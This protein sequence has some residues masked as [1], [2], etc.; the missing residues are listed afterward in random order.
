MGCYKTLALSGG[1]PL[2]T[3]SEQARVNV[4]ATEIVNEYSLGYAPDLCYAMFQTITPLYTEFYV[5]KYNYGDNTVTK[6][7]TMVTPGLGLNM[8]AYAASHQVFVSSRNTRV[9]IYDPQTETLDSFDSGIVGLS[10]FMY[11]PEKGRVYGRMGVD[12]TGLSYIGY[13]DLDLHIVVQLGTIPASGASKPTPKNLVYV[14]SNDCL[15]GCWQTGLG[16]AMCKFNLTTLAGTAVVAAMEGGEIC[17]DTDRQLLIASSSSVKE[18]DPTTD[19]VV[20]TTP[21]TAGGNVSFTPFYVSSLKKVFG[22]GDDDFDTGN[23]A[24]ISYDTQTYASAT[25]KNDFFYDGLCN[26]KDGSFLTDAYDDPG[27]TEGVRRVCLT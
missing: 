6:K 11:V 25:E 10:R 20:R 23:P 2:E 21:I 15:Y 9:I 5:Y 19:T 14:A 26:F 22:I 13:V 24:I 1:C 4:S 12:G 8:W 3:C 7:A 16:A 17:L 18:V 27:A